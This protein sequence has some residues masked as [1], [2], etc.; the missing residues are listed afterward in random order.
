MAEAVKSIFIGHQY[1][2]LE[3]YR[4]SG[5]AVRTPVWFVEEDGKMYV[6]TV[7]TSGKVKRIRRCGQVKSRRATSAVNC[8]DLPWMP[9]RRFTRK[10]ARCMNMATG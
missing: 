7:G 9:K 1:V 6:W 4:K 2:S 5:E 8:L 3:T 10:A